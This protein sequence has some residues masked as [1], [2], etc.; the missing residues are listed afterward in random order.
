MLT[1]NVTVVTALK[2]WLH[3]SDAVLHRLVSLF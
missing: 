2:W 1:G 3:D